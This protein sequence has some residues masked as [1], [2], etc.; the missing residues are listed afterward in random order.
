MTKHDHKVCEHEL[1]HCQKCDECWCVKCEKVWPEKVTQYKG[2]FDD[3]RPKPVQP[4][5][6][7]PNVQ[8]VSES[9]KLPNTIMCS[10]DA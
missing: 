10:H 3:Y 1:K 9:P 4:S 6:L 2:W 7:W 5:P 8:Y